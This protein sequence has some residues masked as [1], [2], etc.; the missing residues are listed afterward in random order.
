MHFVYG[1]REELPKECAVKATVR[2][3]A[4]PVICFHRSDTDKAS[5]QR[6]VRM[7][8]VHLLPGIPQS[9]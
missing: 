8:R 7:D 5:P 3:Q 6:P 9:D 4:A 2:R 1:V